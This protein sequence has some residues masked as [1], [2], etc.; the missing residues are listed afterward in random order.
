LIFNLFQTSYMKITNIKKS[1]SFALLTVLL[2]GC[3][4]KLNQFPPNDLTTQNVFSTPG[5]YKQA[6]AKIYVSMATTSSGGRD[7]P[8]EVVS[9]EGNTD[10][11]RMFWNLQ[12]LSTDEAGWTFHSN[13]DGSTLG[14]HQMQWSSVQEGVAGL[15][16]RS[17][18]IITLVNEFV[19]QSTDANLSSR[20][21]TG[22]AAA[23]IKRYAAEARFIR[24]Y[25]YWILMDLFGNPPIATE[26][27][28]IGVGLPKQK[29]RKELFDYIESELKSIDGQLAAP[30]TNESGRCD[31]AADWALLA[32][33]YLNAKVYTGTERYTD[34][35]TYCKK[36][37][38]AGYSLHPDYTQ[39]MLADND[40]NKDEFI[41]T[42]QYDGQRTQ[43]YGGT[44][45]LIHG[46]ANLPETLMGLSNNWKCI[47]VTQ[48]FSSL[49]DVKD[50]RGQFY[51]TGQSQVM[52]HLL[53]YD[54][55]GWSSYKFRNVTKTGS[56]LVSDPGKTFSDVDFPVFRLAEIYLI[57]AE[58]VV[59][60]GQGG[61]APT[62][63]SYLNLL[64]QRARPSDPNGNILAQLNLNYILDERARELFWEG[65]RRTDLI[66]YDKFTTSSYLWAWKGGVQNG[67]AVDAHLNLYPIP[68]SD[69]VAN[70]NLVQ[71]L[72]Y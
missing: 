19:R 38:G 58:A 7:I 53:D 18:F 4:K 12:C 63:L 23:D 1:L 30:K 13:T 51:T 26:E 65:F 62:A 48:Q 71:N 16:Y 68:N 39:L 46:P 22:Q 28:S 52:T 59:R 33:M 67:T 60:G 27:N 9:D 40:T 14:I 70:P 32:R 15:Y 69:I 34:A 6:L 29:S 64:S 55:E 17:F 5:G 66:R 35:I 25:Q 54:H 20:G 42:I 21:I 41:F 61:D 47:R 2:I 24:A 11:L 36:V 49:F 72:G 8:A 31:Q 37:I 57:Y 45:F 43:T 10:F 56:T 44:T 3:S 50:V